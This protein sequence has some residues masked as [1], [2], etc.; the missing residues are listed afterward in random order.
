MA[1]ATNKPQNA[2]VPV[3]SVARNKATLSNTAASQHCRGVGKS[4]FGKSNFQTMNS[5]APSTMQA[6]VA[7]KLTL[8]SISR[9]RGESIAIITYS[10]RSA[11][12][13]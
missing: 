9:C 12:L 10:P 3:E 11:R 7:T 6:T 5:Q 1:T 13:T 2:D 8:T 4:A